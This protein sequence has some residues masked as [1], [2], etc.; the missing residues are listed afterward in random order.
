MEELVLYFS[1]KYNGEFE[2]IYQAL[3]EKEK[4]DPVLK[5]ELFKKL[6]CNYVTIFSSNYPEALK[7]IKSP[8]FVLYY[9]G[10]LDLVERKNVA[11]VGAT[12]CSMSCEKEIAQL[13][14]ELVENKYCIVSGISSGVSF[15]ATN[16]TLKYQGNLIAVLDS[17]IEKDFPT[18]YTS[19]QS[20]MKENQL[21]IS[22]YP[23]D[24]ESS[25][26]RQCMSNRIVSGLSRSLILGE[27][28]TESTALS[29]VYCSLEAKKNVYCMP[30][31]IL[32]HNQ[33]T[34][35]LIKQGA[36]LLNDVKDLEMC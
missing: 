28:S 15:Y 9:Y 23:F 2:K 34:N 29:A 36:Y 18:I 11:L 14:G 16:E 35:D 19:L 6:K 21:V 20:E 12:K 25:H 13:V 7:Q 22:E 3:K 5:N 31:S 27:C 26:K 30:V 33:V 17:G 24:L 8:P 4:V 10:N 1:L 32:C